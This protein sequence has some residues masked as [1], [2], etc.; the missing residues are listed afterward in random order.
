M[1]EA[2]CFHRTSGP[3]AVQWEPVGI[4]DPRPSEVRA[5]Q[6]TVGPN[7][8]DTNF[9]SGLHPAA[10]P[11][12]VA[13]EAPS[14]IDVV[15]SGVGFEV[16][17]RLTYNGRPLDAYSTEHAMSVAS[18]ITLPDTVGGSAAGSTPEAAHDQG[19]RPSPGTGRCMPVPPIEHARVP[20]QPMAIAMGLH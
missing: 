17:D 18:L 13:D 1:A 12:G 14:E 16:D 20:I 6:L 2:N 5:G 11:A 15:S 4:G 9:R 8:T 10:L 19:V 7:I 3:E